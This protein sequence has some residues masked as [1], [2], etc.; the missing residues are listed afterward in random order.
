MAAV[1]AGHRVEDMR[2]DDHG[3]GYCRIGEQSEYSFR[4]S[5]RGRADGNTDELG[6]E[7]KQAQCGDED[8]DGG[9]E[10]A[11]YPHRNPPVDLCHYLCAMQ[12]SS[13]TPNMFL[14]FPTSLNFT[15]FV[16]MK[17]GYTVRNSNVNKVLPLLR[18]EQQT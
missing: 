5:L 9:G 6:N 1:V 4:T 10:E 8:G 12:K 15:G 7:R 16:L 14:L 18:S 13:S 11:G 2:I 3:D 17:E